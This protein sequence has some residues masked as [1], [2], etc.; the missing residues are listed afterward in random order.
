M[1]CIGQDFFEYIVL[2]NYGF[3]EEAETRSI[4]LL[5]NNNIT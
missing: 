5:D 1:H 3:V 2:P 4:K